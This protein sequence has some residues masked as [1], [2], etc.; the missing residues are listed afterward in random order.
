[1]L[2]ISVPLL[3]PKTVPTLRIIPAFEVLDGPVTI[4]LQIT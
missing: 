3:F 1:M 2:T 4:T